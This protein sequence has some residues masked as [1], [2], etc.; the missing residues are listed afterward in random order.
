VNVKRVES[1]QSE[2]QRRER[3]I[4]PPDPARWSDQLIVMNVFDAL[5]YNTD[6]HPDNLLITEAF[7]VRLID[8]SRSFRPNAELRN[9]DDLSRFPRTLVTRLEKLD[10]STVSKKLGNYLTL[11]QIDGLMKRRDL[12]LDHIKNL[13]NKSS[14]VAVL[15]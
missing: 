13:I 12:L 1:G 3:A 5:I 14:E 7:D 2:R 11:T 8:H 10:K 4:I 6:R 15:Y 9:K